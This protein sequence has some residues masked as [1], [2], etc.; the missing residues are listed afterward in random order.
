MIFKESLG[1]IALEKNMQ[2]IDKNRLNQAEASKSV[3]EKSQQYE[4]PYSIKALG[5]N[6][7]VHREVFSPEHF[8]GWEIF[9]SNFPIVK[10]EDVLEIGCGTGVTGIYL[11]KH[12]AKKVVAVDINP[13]AV[14]NAKENVVINRADNVEVRESD[15]FSNIADTEKFHT[16]YWN[17]PFIY[18][19]ATYQYS[20]MLERGLYDPG[21]QY[22]ERFLKEAKKHLLENG[23]VIAGMA[24]F[25]DLKRFCYLATKYGYTVR[26]IASEKSMEVKPVEFRLYELQP[27]EKNMGKKLFYAMPFTGRSHEEIVRFRH[28]LHEMA[29]KHGLELLEQFIG[30][31]EEDKFESHGYTPLFIAKK[32]HELLKTADIVIAD[33]SD[34]SI[35]RD[36]EIVLANEVFDK[37]VISIVSDPH[38]QNHPYIRLY[39][40]YIVNTPEEAFA[41]SRNLSNFSISSEI[42]G[43][44]RDQKDSIDNEVAELLENKGI[45]AIDVLLPTE[46]SRRWQNLFSS[47]Y[48]DILAWSFRTIPKTVRV[49]TLKSSIED[50][51]H[52]CKKYSWDTEPVLSTEKAYRL[53]STNPAVRFGETA[54]YANG[55]FYVQELAS[56]L[57]PL[58]LDPKPGERVLDICA[59][60]GSKTTQMAELME[61][62]GEILA[63]DNSKPRLEILKAAIER[64]GIDI[65]RPLLEDGA[66]L[67]NS[68]EESFDKVLVDAPCS[69][70]GIIRYKAHKLFEW[71]MLQIYRLME[72]QKKLL[73][74]GFKALKPGGV[75][76]YCTCTYS[77]EEN[78]AIVDSLLRRNQ[79]ADLVSM[80]FKGIKTREG[81]TSWEHI[82]FDKRL[83][84]AIRIYPQDNDTIGFFIAKVVKK[85]Y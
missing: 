14:A 61:N 85:P 46:L 48:R 26:L 22:T 76:V 12:G 82:D 40:N 73:E 58:A 7:I 51:I 45:E 32:D 77:P 30:V 80:Q 18:M 21:Y 5:L 31:E 10:D 2:K 29:G 24:D 44:T 74:S 52:I 3:L 16:I 38:M 54:E 4:F 63:V 20:S 68:Y 60:P 42:S 37:R 81:L 6:I 39:S 59:A 49:N 56:M 43:L 69:C 23:R 25:A 66:V 17:L 70:E 41:L 8:H 27:K 62:R 72:M 33:Y 19:S 15:I 65:I 9:T 13:D 36:C 83:S 11:A 79:S 71:D 55:L 1:L 34:H 53:R 78:E 47:E 35:G 50:F 64:L 28:K 84:K 67:G 57:P 75:L